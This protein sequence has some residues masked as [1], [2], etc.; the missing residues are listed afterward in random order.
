MHFNKVFPN[1]VSLAVSLISEIMRML[2]RR[3][4]CIDFGILVTQNSQAN[5]DREYLTQA[6]YKS[7][8]KK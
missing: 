7:L 2:S 4:T 6:H 3:L 8:K 1:L 5:T